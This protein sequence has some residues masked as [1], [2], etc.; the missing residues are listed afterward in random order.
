MACFKN[1]LVIS[2]LTNIT[3]ILLCYKLKY[4]ILYYI[5]LHYIVFK[6]YNMKVAFCLYGQPRNYKSCYQNIKKFVAN[7][8]KCKFD[9]FIHAWIIE[10]GKTYEHSPWRNIDEIDLKACKNQENDI[11]KL[12]NPISYKFQH[13][14]SHFEL[15]E[16]IISSLAYKNTN[17]K[18]KTNINNTISQCYSR[19]IVKNL[20]ESYV[21]KTNIKYDVVII[22]RF[23]FKKNISFVFDD[24]INNKIY[25]SDLHHPRKIT[26]DN[27]IISPYNI[28]VKWFDLYDNLENLLNN[29]NIYL[30]MQENGEK[31]IIN[32]EELIM[33]N[34]IYHFG[35]MKN[36]EY[37]NKIPNFI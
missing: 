35:E 3:I 32:P 1:T 22:C 2:F 16:K 5:I 29:H 27:F 25:V 11:K 13:S 12:Y 36:I 14:I 10:H 34:Y 4:I 30:K 28:F 24:Y 7:N 19:T 26:P 6:I 33:A 20:L 37:T 9:F 15:S 17:I 8:K 18:L 31:L 21:N 23:D